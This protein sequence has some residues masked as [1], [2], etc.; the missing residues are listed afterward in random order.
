MSSIMHAALGNVR[1]RMV[2]AI[3]ALFALA[4][5]HTASAQPYERSAYQAY[6][7]T[8]APILAGPTP[9]YPPVV[10]LNPGQPVAVYGCL[11]GYSWCD[12][13]IEGYRGWFDAGLLSYPYE[14][15]SVPLYDYGYRIGIP[16][17][18]FSFDDY[19]RRYYYDR[20]FFR[21]RERW[22]RVPPPR[23]REDRPRE[24]HPR[25]PGLPGF[26]EGRVPGFEEHRGEEPNRP[27]GDRGQFE[28]GQGGQPEREGRPPEGRPPEGR[29]PEGR[30]PEGQRPAEQQRPQQ[31]QRPAPV[32]P[33]AAPHAPQPQTPRPQPQAP[34]PQ[35][36]PPAAHPPAPAAK[37]AEPHP[38]RPNPEEPPK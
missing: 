16:V 3:A 6:V 4:V 8:P 12:V 9:D 28:H 33:A 36:A 15:G 22:A 26:L 17:I 30:P 27:G 21:E 31:A 24:D 19:W 38:A 2:L 18:G 5:G 32:N 1:A 11:D 29:P 37:P 10:D 34:H 35:A 7:T 20:P 14:G 23:P 25:V 13:A